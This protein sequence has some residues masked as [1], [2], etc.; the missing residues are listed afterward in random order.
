MAKQFS[1][2]P[3]LQRSAE[4]LGLTLTDT[5]L[6]QLAH[7]AQMLIDGSKRANL[8]A[9][10]DWDGVEARHLLDSLTLVACI[11]EPGLTR[12][13]SLVDIGSGAGFPGLPLAIVLPHLDVT[14]V[15][16]TGKKVAFAARAIEAL[17]L[18][19]ARAVHVRAEA[20]GRDPAYREHFDLAAVRAVGSLAADIELAAPLLRLGGRAF[21]M[22]KLGDS[23]SEVAA[24]GSML[25]TLGC[26]VEK[27]ADVSLPEV[28]PERAVVVVRK[29]AP[30]A[31]GYPR[32]PGLAQRRHR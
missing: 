14:L 6:M 12:A 19:N 9:I 7:L 31:P 22:K 15:E 5:Q 26:V 25:E 1:R 13:Q 24:V 2:L 17:E 8:T 32:R 28:L 18:E 27:V 21:I 29:R 3:I 20:A 10:T 30:T 4:A 11:S 23:G 16:A